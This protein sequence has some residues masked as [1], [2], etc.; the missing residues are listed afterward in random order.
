MQFFVVTKWSSQWVI[1]ASK[2]NWLYTS[3]RDPDSEISHI[4]YRILIFRPIL[5]GFFFFE[6]I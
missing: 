1:D 6:F 3:K 5:K 4:I 2:Q